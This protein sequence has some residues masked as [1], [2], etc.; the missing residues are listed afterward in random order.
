MSADNP[1]VA[2]LDLEMGAV[3][4][5]KPKSFGAAEPQ[6]FAANAAGASSVGTFL[7]TV[8]NYIG[9]FVKTSIDTP[10]ERQRIK[11]AVLA[12]FDSYVAPSLGPMVRIAI[13]MSLDAIVTNA[14]ETF[15]S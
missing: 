15:G 4:G 10:E 13:R 11:D 2:A 1:H 7:M 8:L 3:F 12:A 9:S 14:L 6:D 5:G